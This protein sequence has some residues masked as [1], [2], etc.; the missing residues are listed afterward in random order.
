MNQLLEEGQKLDLKY[1][2]PPDLAI[3]IDITSSSVNKFDLLSVGCI[4][5]GDMMG[6]FEIISVVENMLECEFSAAF[7]LVSVNEISRFMEQK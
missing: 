4:G 7:P 3:E 1:D 5:C 6:R 2:P